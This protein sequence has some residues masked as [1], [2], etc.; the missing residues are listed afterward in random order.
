M[1]D[2]WVSSSSPKFYRCYIINSWLCNCI[3]I[4]TPFD[5][6]HLDQENTCNSNV[7]NDI[8]RKGYIK[9]KYCGEYWAHSTSQFAQLSTYSTNL[10]VLTTL[11]MSFKGI[12]GNLFYLPIS[13]LGVSL[14]L[15]ST[16]ST[17]I[18]LN[19]S[20]PYDSLHSRYIAETMKL[21]QSG[22]TVFHD[23]HLPTLQV[24]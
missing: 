23:T 16:C 3:L 2:G 18:Y 13:V 21:Q 20:I 11:N 8:R 10:K 4:N 24:T 7:L 19:D 14:I 22:Y 12:T 15:P 1:V 9:S 5:R 17:H 6:M